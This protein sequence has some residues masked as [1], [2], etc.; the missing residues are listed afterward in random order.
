MQSIFRA[1]A[2]P[3]SLAGTDERQPL[4]GPVLA[5]VPRKRGYFLK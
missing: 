4:T 2:P 3:R 5:Y 1:T